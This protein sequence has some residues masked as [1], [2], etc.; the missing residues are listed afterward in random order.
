VTTSLVSNRRPL[1]E[2]VYLTE[3]VTPKTYLVERRAPSLQGFT[4]K[5]TIHGCLDWV[6]RNIRYRSERGDVWYFPA[7]AIQ[8]GRGDCEESS[9]LTCSLLRACGLSS[10]EIF[11]ALGLHGRGGH[12]WCALLD[13]GK[14]WAL[15]TTLA[16]APESIPEQ[17]RPYDPW[18]L[19]NDAKAI[20]LKSGFM[21]VMTKAHQK[22]KRRQIEDFYGIMVG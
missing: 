21:G 10:D 9:F 13:A 14:Y 15:E 19:F 2:E 1:G 12:A 4:R 3:F 17:V 22:E 11:V 7:E 18:V 16:R 20:E 6:C 8:I 5:E